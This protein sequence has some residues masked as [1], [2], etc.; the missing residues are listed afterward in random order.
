MINSPAGKEIPGYE[1]HTGLL[2]AFSVFF[3]DLM[4]L[5]F[6]SFFLYIFIVNPYDGTPVPLFELLFVLVV[7][8]LT[9]LSSIIIISYPTLSYYHSIILTSNE[10]RLKNIFGKSNSIKN[11]DIFSVNAFK[12][13]PPIR[14]QPRVSGYVIRIDYGKAG[15]IYSKLLCTS[16][17]KKQV[18]D[19]VSL[20]KS[21][22]VK[23][24]LSGK[25]ILLSSQRSKP[26]SL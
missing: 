1:Q 17:N 20:I 15:S 10:V 19:L 14:W 24:Q 26:K 16:L 11:S 22:M 23:N 13:V 5:S 7:V 6:M 4:L 12:E 18:E 9:I 2:R 3:V 21:Q 25:P 8:I